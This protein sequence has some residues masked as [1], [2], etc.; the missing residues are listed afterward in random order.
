MARQD[1]EK[2]LYP[3]TFLP[4]KLPE[5]PGETYSIADLGF[6][7]SEIEGGW[8]SGNTL[9]ELMQTYLERVVG[10]TSFEY[11]GIQFPV[12][13]KT[14]E[15]SG[16]TPLRVNTDDTA[17]GQRYDAFGKTA[18]WYIADAGPDAFLYLGPE[19]DMTAEGLYSKFLDGKLSGALHMVRPH[20][21]EA[22]L[23][24][25]G[26]MHAAGGRMRIIEISEASELSFSIHGWSAGEDSSA[27]EEAF[28]LIDFRA[29]RLLPTEGPGLLSRT[30]H[31]TVSEIHLKEPLRS[32]KDSSDS[33][34]FVL[35]TCVS[36]AA[37][38]QEASAGDGGKAVSCTVRPGGTVLVP[39]EV[40]EFYIVP[41]APSTVLLETT[42]EP[43]PQ[44][45]EF[46]P[47][48]SED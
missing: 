27:L 44:E 13:V 46:P 1:S 34:S 39:E 36:G 48:D 18:L 31:F 40:D 10:E 41:S 30:P 14:I 32:V 43:R 28:D 6:A 33:G 7:D 20:R 2:K 9:S 3:M 8:L 25:P 35:Y 47:V 23:I 24:S 17:A 22:Y 29:V 37:S 26:M 4:V 15:V 42:L 38:I 11:Y 21:G 5:L 19:E 12:M 45:P 16:R